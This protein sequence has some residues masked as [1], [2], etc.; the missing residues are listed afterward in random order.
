M[1]GKAD[2]SAKR[3]QEKKKQGG[4]GEHARCVSQKKKILGREIFNRHCQNTA[5]LNSSGWKRSPMLREREK[6]LRGGGGERSGE[7]R[8]KGRKV[9]REGHSELKQ[10]EGHFSQGPPIQKK[11]VT[12]KRGGMRG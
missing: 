11:K 12:I 1:G 2:P 8:R 3:E 9:E 7:K 4:G 5:D 6:S 10:E